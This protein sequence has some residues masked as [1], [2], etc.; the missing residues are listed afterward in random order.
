MDFA[1]HFLVVFV[2]GVAVFGRLHWKKIFPF[3]CLAAFPDFD[4]VFSMH[5]QLFHNIFFAI[6]AGLLVFLAAR[7][8]WKKR[9]AIL[10]GWLGFFAVVSHLVLDLG[11]P[12]LALFWPLYEKAVFF[13]FKAMV[14]TTSLVPEISFGVA[15]LS[16]SITGNS[17]NIE[18]VFLSYETFFVAM[19]FVLFF[20]LVWLFGKRL[21]KGGLFKK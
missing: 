10:L 9:D 7:F 6:I 11:E 20:A 17:F 19:L 12:G 15:E 2:L 13:Q 14:Y 1:A 4:F 8:V 16:E 21:D 18:R 3:A 5:R